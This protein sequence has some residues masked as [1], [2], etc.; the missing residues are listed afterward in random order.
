MLDQFKVIDTRRVKVP[1][2]NGKS[3]N[4]L[5]NQITQNESSAERP[6]QP[7]VP[8]P[9]ATPSN[10]I[11]STP[12]P[13]PSV[14]KSSASPS[15]NSQTSTAPTDY[16]FWLAWSC[17]VASQAAWI[18]PML[19]QQKQQGQ[20]PPSFPNDPEA[21]AKFLQAM[22]TAM[23]PL[24]TAQASVNN[25]NNNNNNDDDDD[26]DDGNERTEHEV[27]LETSVVV[28]EETNEH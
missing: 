13:Q 25:N 17:Y 20:L 5:N 7:R 27:E 8:S 28:K 1:A 16:G 18:S 24:R 21:A 26:D 4:N 12:T 23:E 11:N 14:P 22:R 2:R 10:V 19:Q 15:N 9:T 6:I 3:V